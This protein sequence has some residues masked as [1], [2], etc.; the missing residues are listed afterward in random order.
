MQNG[1][2]WRHPSPRIDVQEH[3]L[4]GFRHQIDAGE[5]RLRLES[6]LLEPQTIRREESC[7]SAQPSCSASVAEFSLVKLSRDAALECMSNHAFG[8]P[9]DLNAA[10]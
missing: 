5:T 10:D 1:G 2:E 6:Q 7:G 9:G 4:V 8:A 3:G